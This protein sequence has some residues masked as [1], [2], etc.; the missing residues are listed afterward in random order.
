MNYIVQPGDTLFSIARSY[1]T[2]VEQLMQ[3]NRLTTDMLLVGQNLYIPMLRQPQTV[4]TVQPGDTLYLIAQRFNT[5]VESIIALNNLTSTALN[6]GQRLQIPLY[7]EVVVNVDQA[8][9]RRGPGTNF[10]IAARMVRGARLPVTASYQN[11]YRVRL[12]NGS[13][14]WIR[15]DLVTRRVHGGRKPIT[16]I[17]GFYTLEE[18]PALPSSFSSFVNNTAL[19]SDVPLFF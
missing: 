11:W 12:F 6:I 13:P 17:V 15:E 10:D 3:A 16:G 9:I 4:Y 7:T 5:T 1:G 2:S 19:L 18:G 8:N 14:G